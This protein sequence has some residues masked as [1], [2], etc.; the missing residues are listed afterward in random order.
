MYSF[1]NE[2]MTWGLG[3]VNRTRFAVALVIRI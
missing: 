2:P 3:G 1:P